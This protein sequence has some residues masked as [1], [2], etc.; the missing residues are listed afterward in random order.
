MLK[1]FQAF[2][3]LREVIVE[4]QREPTK[5]EAGVEKSSEQQSPPYPLKK[6]NPWK[7]ADG[8]LPIVASHGVE[9]EVYK[10]LDPRLRVVILKALCDIRVEQ[11]DIRN[12]IDNSLKQGVQLSAFRKERT[13]GDS[14]GMFYWYEDDPIIGHRLYRELRKA[15][16]K[17]AK[18]KGSQVPSNVSY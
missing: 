7:V 8:E 1:L 13:G 17:K 5:M 15:E 9:V 2:S 4:D 12:Y 16:V 14:H 10:M 6:R 3:S 11:E 18:R